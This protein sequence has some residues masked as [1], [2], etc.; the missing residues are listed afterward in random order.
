MYGLG[1]GLRVNKAKKKDK[2]QE[3]ETQDRDR[4]KIER[5][6]TR[7]MPTQLRQDEDE[8]IRLSQAK[9]NQITLIHKFSPG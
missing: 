1:L 8:T 4:G 3:Q 5:Q 7:A 9:T 6:E 2:R